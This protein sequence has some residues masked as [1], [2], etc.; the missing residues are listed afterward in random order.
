MVQEA[1]HNVAKHAKATHV[2]VGLAMT[3]GLLNAHVTDDG[4]GFDMQAESN[5]PEKWDHFGL[6][7]MMERARMLMGDVQWISK[8]GKGTCVTIQVPIGPKEKL[9][10]GK[11]N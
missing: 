10:D 7:G 11:K 2:N 1:L 6:R 8:K 5:N 9:S 4:I 3:N